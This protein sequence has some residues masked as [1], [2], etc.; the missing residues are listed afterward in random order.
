MLELRT[1][2]HWDGSPEDRI[3]HG[4]SGIAR[5]VAASTTWGC[6]DLM[7]ALFSGPLLPNDDSHLRHPHCITQ[8]IPFPSQ[9]R[10]ILEFPWCGIWVQL[11]LFRA[12]A[13]R[14]WS[15]PDLAERATAQDQ[16]VG[17]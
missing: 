12:P 1:G 10:A 9:K 5:A 2:T 6:G 8:K 17:G 4:D 15:A 3:C 13:P 16:A 11:S 14:L 7:A